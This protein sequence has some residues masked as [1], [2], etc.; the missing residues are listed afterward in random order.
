MNVME[1]MI[2]VI[3]DADKDADIKSQ[4]DSLSKKMEAVGERVKVLPEQTAAEK[5]ALT[6]KMKS[7]ME[8]MQANMMAAMG[9]LMTDP[10]VMKAFQNAMSKVGAPG[11]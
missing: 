1:E 3:N 10:E 6:E 11:K 2:A 7:R 9:K 5:K 8:K 4:I